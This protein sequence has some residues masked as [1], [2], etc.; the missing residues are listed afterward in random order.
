MPTIVKFLAAY[1]IA[2]APA[3]AQPGPSFACSK[4]T[5]TTER[6]ICA[7]PRLSEL[8]DAL[9]KSYRYALMS[10]IGDGAARWVRDSQRKWLKLRSACG[11]DAACLATSYSERIDQICAVPVLTGAH[12]HCV[13]PAD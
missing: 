6:T 1:L 2:T 7:V 12:S 11:A 5:T 9:D 13:L 4:A 10:N 8:D 3:M